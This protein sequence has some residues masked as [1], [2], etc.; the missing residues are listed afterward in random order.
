MTGHRAVSPASA[1]VE[2][3]AHSDL[4][5]ASSPESIWQASSLLF[6]PLLAG[7]PSVHA[8]AQPAATCVLSPHPQSVKASRDF[9]RVALH[10]WGMAALADVAELVVSELVTNALRHGVPFAHQV[11]TNHQ[12]A[13]SRQAATNRPVRLRLLAQAPLVMCMVSDPSGEIPVLRE[14]DL[15]AESGRGLRV[16]Q[17]CS[18]RWGWH[19]LDGGGKIVWALL[20]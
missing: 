1:E 3:A 5:T 4:L 18:V 15:A 11:V 10:D 20:R 17:A 6:A 16:V 19:L 9:T 14:S 8:P 2:H 13:T 12:A 7:S